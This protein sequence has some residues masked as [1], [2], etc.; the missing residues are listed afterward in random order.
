MMS[1]AQTFNRITERG[2]EP[3]VVSTQ[4]NTLIS[5]YLQGVVMQG[6]PLRRMGISRTQAQA[7]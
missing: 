7:S 1:I 3:T 2:M 4:K 6:R 5:K